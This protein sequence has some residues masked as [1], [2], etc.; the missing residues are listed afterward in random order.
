MVHGMGKLT[1]L[2]YFVAKLRSTI[3]KL[4]CIFLFWSAVNNGFGYKSRKNTYQTLVNERNGRGDDD[5]LPGLVAPSLGLV[6]DT[7]SGISPP[8]S[9]VMIYPCQKGIQYG[10]KIKDYVPSLIASS[11]DF[12]S[13]PSGIMFGA[14]EVSKIWY[15][16]HIRS[17]IQDSRIFTD[18]LEES[19]HRNCWALQRRWLQELMSV[20]VA[21]MR[22]SHWG[23]TLTRLRSTSELTRTKIRCGRGKSAN[24]DFALDKSG[25]H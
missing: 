20:L 13:G 25:I 2:G 19:R 3:D 23:D 10:I 22:P 5:C 16:S 11:A 12:E 9:G 17:E 24:S 7:S 1:R 6:A 14:V 4:C 15:K 18:H 21:A 8:F